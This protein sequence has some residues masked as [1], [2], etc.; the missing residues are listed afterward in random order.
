MYDDL[1]ARRKDELEEDSLLIATESNPVAGIDLEMQNHVLGVE[2]AVTSARVKGEQC[3]GQNTSD[4]SETHDEATDRYLESAV[5]DAKL[6]K[7]ITG[8]KKV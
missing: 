5:R 6:Q 4:S 2:I 3:D 1:Q 8:R 7:E